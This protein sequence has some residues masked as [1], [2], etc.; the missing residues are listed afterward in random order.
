MLEHR[1]KRRAETWDTMQLFF[2]LYN[3]HQIHAVISFNGHLDEQRLEK[4]ASLT[5]DAV[6][7]IKSRFVEHL[8]RAYWEEALVDHF[9]SLYATDDPEKEI[10]R[11]ITST[12]DE[13]SGPQL[14]IKIV[15]TPI[16]DTLCILVNHMVCDAAGFKEYLYLLSE[17]YTALATNPGY[18]L[19]YSCG[20]RSM[21]Q[22]FRAFGGWSG[23]LKILM[24]PHGMSKHDCGLKFPLE[25]DLSHP[26]IVTRK[27]PGDR[28]WAI[29]SYGKTREATINDVILAAYIRSLYNFLGLEDGARVVVPCAVDLR[30]YLPERKAQGICNLTSTIACEI[31]HNSH[32]RFDETLK[33][34]KRSMDTEKNSI[35]C[36]SGPMKLE[37]FRWILPYKLFK[38]WLKKIFINPKIF[39]TN[40]GVIDKTKLSF[41]GF[42]SSAYLTGS[43]KYNPYFQLALTTF[44]DEITFSV[45][46]YGTQN[47]RDR[48]EDFLSLVEAELPE[49]GIRK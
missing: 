34:V 9:V 15:R 25:G 20:S 3:D 37:I 38:R 42:V 26:F 7:V 12:I 16:A 27:L 47:D 40:I 22:V 8:L 6:P 23:M 48:I 11:L 29:K 35:S 33:K 18:K 10:N 13:R 49:S 17:T 45:N 1:N 46:F 44:D 39:M 24:A 43:I 19:Q 36:L 30:K 14:Q 41:G 2:S 31:N 32:D 4:A 21:S 28:M 5:A